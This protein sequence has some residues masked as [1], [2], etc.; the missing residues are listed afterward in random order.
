MQIGIHQMIL[1]LRLTCILKACLPL[2]LYSE[3][4]YLCRLSALWPVSYGSFSLALVY[5]PIPS[6]RALTFSLSLAFCVVLSFSIWRYR[7]CFY[8][9]MSSI[10]HINPVFSV[11][12][13]VSS[14]FCITTFSATAVTG[15]VTAVPVLNTTEKAVLITC[16]LFLMHKFI[17]FTLLVQGPFKK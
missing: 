13:S 4:S 14:V 6:N 12:G 9:T 2:E 17:I 10:Y 11:S 15:S 7:F 8:H 16:D 1:S 3:R 5:P